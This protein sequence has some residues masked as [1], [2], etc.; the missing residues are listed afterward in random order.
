LLSST[1][2]V[3]SARCDALDVINVWPKP[4]MAEISVPVPTEPRKVLTAPAAMTLLIPRQIPE[5]TSR[6]RR[7]SPVRVQ[8]I[9]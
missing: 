2:G 5:T 9:S 3:T 4:M 8:K 1:N 6:I 7:R